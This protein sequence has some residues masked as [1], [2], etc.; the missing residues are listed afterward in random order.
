MSL[1]T[2]NLS[3]FIDQIDSDSPAPG[4]G[5]VAAYAST[6]GLALAKM[7]CHLTVTKKKYL[8]LDEEVRAEF[9][10]RMEK[11]DSYKEELLAKVDLDTEAFESV[12]AAFRMPKTT[13]SEIAIRDLEI[14]EATINAIRVPY[15]VM[16]LTYATLKELPYFIKYGNVN[17]LSDLGSAFIL[18]KAGLD[19]AYLNVKINLG[20]LQDEETS[21]YYQERCEEMIEASE[22]IVSKALEKISAKI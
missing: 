9:E 1:L 14:K 3:E 13:E 18:L 22:L 2:N 16:S 20:S 6:L 10:E 7:L 19:C 11:I 5:S 12:M 8:A 21:A 17:A 4:G 15:H